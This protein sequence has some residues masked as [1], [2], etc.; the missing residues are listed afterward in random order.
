MW[1]T[2]PGKPERCCLG[3]A[4]GGVVKSTKGLRASRIIGPS[5][6]TVILALDHAV[7]S[8]PVVGLKNL[9]ATVAAIWSESDAVIVH[10]GIL[11][12]GGLPVHPPRGVIAHL[13]G[14]T[15]Y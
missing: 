10:R 6:K 5:G 3:I 11:Q 14:G 1:G 7:S 8:G 12:Q 2:C 9:P 4:D 13:S 15:T